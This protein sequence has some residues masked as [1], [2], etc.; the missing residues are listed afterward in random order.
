MNLFVW[1]LL[2][3]LVLG[4]FFPRHGAGRFQ[5]FES[6]V[7]PYSG[8]DPNEWRLFVK[9]LRDFDSDTTGQ[10]LY[11]A[12]E[13]IRNI[14]LMNTNFT[15][16]INAIADRLG[17]EG[18]VFLNQQAVMKGTIFRPKFLNDVIPDQPITLYL[19]DSKPMDTIYVNPVGA[20]VGR[21]ALGGS[22]R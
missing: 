6:K 1:I 11:R 4:I 10:S 8:L 13:H 12:I 18:E 17:Y 16:E 20:T 9:E 22:H 3:A 14:G 2:L 21:G 7:H 5:A 19:N 15:D